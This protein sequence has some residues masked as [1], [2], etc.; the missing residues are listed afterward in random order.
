[1]ITLACV[2]IRCLSQN[3]QDAL[4]YLANGM[5]TATCHIQRKVQHPTSA[6]TRRMLKRLERDGLVRGECWNGG[7]VR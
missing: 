1:M 6:V 3:Q 4:S 5:S 7:K 2:K